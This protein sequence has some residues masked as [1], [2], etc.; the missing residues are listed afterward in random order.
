LARQRFVLAKEFGVREAR[1]RLST[2]ALVF[3]RTASSL[4]LVIY[5]LYLSM[6]DLV[7]ELGK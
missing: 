1:S 6:F 2:T 3:V 5:V 4:G 7:N